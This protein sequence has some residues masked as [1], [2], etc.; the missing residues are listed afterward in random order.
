MLREDATLALDAFSKKVGIDGL[1]FDQS[2]TALLAFGDHQELILYYAEPS[3]EIQIW[4][5]LSDLMLSGKADFDNA[6]MQHLLEKNFPATTLSGSYFAV[7]GE[8]GVVLLGRAVSVDVHNLDRFVETVTAFAQ[9]ALTIAGTI[10][11]D[12]AAAFAARDTGGAMDN[13][14]PIIKA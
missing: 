14:T 5:P 10:E 11:N 9:Q 4:C 12:V 6:M 8:L 13:D 3:N 7:D 1:R 2:G